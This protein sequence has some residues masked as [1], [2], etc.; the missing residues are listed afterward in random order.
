MESQQTAAGVGVAPEVK[1]RLEDYMAEIASGLGRSDQRRAAALYAR[2]LIAEGKRKS[3]EPMVARLGGGNVEYEGLQHFLADSPWDPEVIDRAV[4]ERVCPVIEP[5]AWVIDDTGV[6]KGRQAFAGGQA[7][8][9]GD[10]GHDGQLSGDGVA[11]RGRAGWHSAVGVQA[12][13]AA[14][15]V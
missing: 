8:V 6:V 10:A 7:P 11:A 1:Q 15:V 2:G 9:L 3:P 13:P 4:A 14:G 5:Q 12:V